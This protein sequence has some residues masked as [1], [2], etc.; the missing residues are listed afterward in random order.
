MSLSVS[1]S[2]TQATKYLRYVVQVSPVA[3]QR[4]SALLLTTKLSKVRQP[5]ERIRR[6]VAAVCRAPGKH[7]A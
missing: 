5:I 4:E 1:C 6:S 3:G 2:L 7:A